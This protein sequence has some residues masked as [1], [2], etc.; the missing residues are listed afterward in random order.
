MV[1]RI[2]DNLLELSDTLPPHIHVL[3]FAGRCFVNAG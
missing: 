3:G 1:Y 2:L